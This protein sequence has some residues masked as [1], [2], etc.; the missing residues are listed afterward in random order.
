MAAE[1]L[2]LYSDQGAN[3]DALQNPQAGQVYNIEDAQG[4]AKNNTSY[5]AE[6]Y[7]SSD[8]AGA[9][10]RTLHPGEAANVDEFASVKFVR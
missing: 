1:E 8:G 7:M 3:P 2:T 5:D 4:Q 9:V 10:A 6:L